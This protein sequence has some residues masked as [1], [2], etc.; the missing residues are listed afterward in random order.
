MIGGKLASIFAKKKPGEQLDNVPEELPENPEVVQ[1]RREF[2]MSGV[3]SELKRQAACTAPA[4]ISSECT[5]FPEIS[6]VQQQASVES[7]SLDVLS[8]AVPENIKA[9]VQAKDE[10]SKMEVS[11]LKWTNLQWQPIVNEHRKFSLQLQ[12]CACL[13]EFRGGRGGSLHGIVFRISCIFNGAM[14]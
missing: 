14:V 2:L 8:L 1:K 3:P 12:V 7:G 9:M 5:P 4:T 10:L 6:H 13:I 11:G